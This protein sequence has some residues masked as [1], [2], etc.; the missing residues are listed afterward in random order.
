MLR[1]MHCDFWKMQAAC[2]YYCHLLELPRHNFTAAHS[3]EDVESRQYNGL[4]ID[5]CQAML[6]IGCPH[7]A[8]LANLI[9]EDCCCYPQEDGLAFN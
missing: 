5:I 1:H 3:A 8:M 6:I 9:A 7:R 4:P 2:S